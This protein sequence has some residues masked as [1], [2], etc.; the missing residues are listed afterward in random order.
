MCQLVEI[1]RIVHGPAL[2]PQVGEEFERQVDKCAGARDV[3]N[4]VV[5]HHCLPVVIVQQGSNARIVIGHQA[6]DVRVDGVLIDRQA[7]RF[8]SNGRIAGCRIPKVVGEGTLQA[9]EIGFHVL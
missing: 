5:A 9:F 8:L 1:R 6:G 3:T 2:V 7:T 4:D